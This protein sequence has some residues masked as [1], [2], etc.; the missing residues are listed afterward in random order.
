[1]RESRG[2]VIITTKARERVARAA[3]KKVLEEIEVNKD[4]AEK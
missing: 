3:R 2:L 1:M 4:R